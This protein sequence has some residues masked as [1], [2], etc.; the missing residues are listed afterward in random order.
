[1][2]QNKR[3]IAFF[4]LQAQLFFHELPIDKFFV[5]TIHG[6][7]LLVVT[8][9]NDFSFAQYNDLV[10]IANSWEPVSDDD[11]SLFLSWN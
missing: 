9:F 10:S 8:N 4:D 7:Q 11:A 6:N 2:A 5:N 3:S 1:M